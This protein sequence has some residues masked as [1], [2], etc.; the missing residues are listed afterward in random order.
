[1][2]DQLVSKKPA[3]QKKT[4]KAPKMTKA[5]QPQSKTQTS[6]RR[7]RDALANISKRSRIGA[8]DAAVDYM[9][10]K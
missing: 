6:T 3:A 1:L 2:Y 9:T 4:Q 10:Q 5:G 7:K 8:V